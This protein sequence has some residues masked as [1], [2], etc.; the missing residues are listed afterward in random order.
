MNISANDA[1]RAY[2]SRPPAIG[3]MTFGL[4]TGSWYGTATPG[5]WDYWRAGAA[6]LRKIG[7]RVTRVGSQK[8]G[9]WQVTFDGHRATQE[10]I[11]AALVRVRAA[12]AKAG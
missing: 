11:E 1:Y 7:F 2:G 3:G 5:F 12:M 6:E 8:Y 9:H 10:Q 4:G